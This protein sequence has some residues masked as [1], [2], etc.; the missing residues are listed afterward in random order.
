MRRYV[1]YDEAV[2]KGAVNYPKVRADSLKLSSL[3]PQK[4]CIRNKALHRGA[5]D[6]LFSFSP[7]RPKKQQIPRAKGAREG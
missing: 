2:G 6:L 3:A 7:R 5:G 1:E 4:Y